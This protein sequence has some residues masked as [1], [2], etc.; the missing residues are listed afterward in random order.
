MY[1]K[2]SNIIG[3]LKTYVCHALSASEYRY[4]Q[5]GCYWISKFSVSW[6]YLFP[7]VSEVSDMIIPC[8]IFKGDTWTIKSL[9]HTIWY[10]HVEKQVVHTKRSMKEWSI[11]SVCIGP[12][13]NLQDYYNIITHIQCSCI[14]WLTYTP[15][16]LLLTCSKNRGGKEINEEF[17]Q[18]YVQKMLNPFKNLSK[19]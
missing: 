4:I 18:L 6:L 1:Q 2:L 16:T 5:L 7:V 13:I 11:E 8:M 15:L 14:I 19:K 10:I 9:M 3:L 12:Y 17:K